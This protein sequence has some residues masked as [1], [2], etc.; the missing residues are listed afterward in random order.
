MRRLL[1]YL[2][3]Y[4]GDVALAIV[5]ALLETA[6]Q[7]T[8]PYLTKEA[9]DNGI[10]HRDMLHL[11]RVALLYLAVLMVGYLL[12][13][14]ETRIMQ[15]DGQNFMLDL[16]LQLFRHLQRLPIAYFDR[17]A[18]GRIMTPCPTLCMIW[19]CR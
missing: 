4:R 7:L 2:R 3:P 8:G 19:V 16:R 12:A 6:V 11:D 14:L 5:V 17:T 1:G 18:V 15:R 13:Y 9:I 10:R